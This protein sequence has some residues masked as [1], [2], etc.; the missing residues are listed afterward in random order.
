MLAQSS[1]GS[2][3]SAGC[4][5][6]TDRQ[7]LQTWS[8]SPALERTTKVRL[9]QLRRVAIKKSALVTSPVF[10]GQFDAAETL[11]A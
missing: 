3:S 8:A 1:L 4:S 9:A 6:A 2:P 11:E 10:N 7:A 5:R